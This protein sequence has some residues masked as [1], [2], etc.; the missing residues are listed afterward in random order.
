[1]S[2]ADPCDLQYALGTLA[3]SNS[4]LWVRAGVYTPG[5]SDRNTTFEM[6]N[7][8]AIY[9]GFAGTETVRGQRNSNPATNGTVLS[10]DIGTIGVIADN[11]YRVVSAFGVSPSAVLDGFTVTGGNAN[12]G[13]GH[14]GGIFIQDGSPTF[15]NLIINNN[16]ASA[17]GGGVFVL[18]LG[19]VRTSYSSPS[20]TNVTISNNTAARGGG[21]YTQ[22][23]S[24]VLADVTFSGNTATSGAGGGMNNQVLNEAT[25]EYSLPLLTNVTFSG[26]T[27]NGGGGLFNNHSYPILTNVTFSGNTANIRGGAILNEGA[28]PILRNVTI[29]GNTAPAGFGGSIRNVQN[30][31]FAPSNPQI[32]NSILWGNGTDEITS[33]GTGSTTVVDSVV[34]GGFAGTNVLTA[35]PN[36]GVLAN[37]GGNTQTHAISAGSSAL[38]AGGVN[39]VCAS[40]DQ[41]GVVRP[42]GAGCDMGAYEYQAP[43]AVTPTNTTANTP[44]VTATFTP[45][46]SNTPTITPSNTPTPTRTPT[47]SAT[48]VPTNTPL[49]GAND[50]MYMSSTSSGTAGSVSFNDEDILSYN[51]ATGT[52]A[53]YF[54]GSDVGVSGDV[55][56]FTLMA[57]GSILLSLD[58]AATVGSLG[59]VDDSDVVR[60]IPT[61]LGTNTAGSFTMYFDGSDVGL[62]TNEEDIDSVGFAPDGRL[63]IGTIDTVSVTGASGSGEDLLA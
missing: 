60:F 42:Q 18:S 22:N 61:S 16:V 52:W 49:P 14:G 9:G 15:A 58:A 38:D 55:N 21:L 28:N 29:T 37:N 32:Y 53:M 7:G 11:V 6:K 48:P 54:D 40:T 2:W 47:A 3:G 5:T 1:T 19:T 63:I 36:L 24:P 57:D 46:A 27:A 12:G 45:T 30:A 25:D 59:T 13:T 10:G 51:R 41:R 33:D 62:S 26:N 8:I 39:S 17:N 23:S 31:V 35:N 20:F 34:Q 50:V 43:P 4:E 56:A 44:T